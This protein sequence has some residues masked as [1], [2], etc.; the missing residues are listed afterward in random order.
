MCSPTSLIHSDGFSR[1]SRFLSATFYHMYPRVTALCMGYEPSHRC[2]LSPGPP[3]MR[4]LRVAKCTASCPHNYTPT[5]LRGPSVRVEFPKWVVPAQVP[6][7]KF[8]IGASFRFLK[9]IML[10][11]PGQ[12]MHRWEILCLPCGVLRRGGFPW[13]VALTNRES[14]EKPSERSNTYGWG[15]VPRRNIY[16]YIYIYILCC[17]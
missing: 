8:E 10:G 14:R 13:K 9:C 1:L 7:L 4:H 15:V 6:I 3:I 12:R 17:R 5:S 2:L 16:K 11:G